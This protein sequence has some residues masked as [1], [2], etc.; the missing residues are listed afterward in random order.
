MSEPFLTERYLSIWEKLIL[1]HGCFFVVCLVGFFCCCCCFL[2][3]GGLLGWFFCGFG[4]VLSLFS[5]F[6]LLSICDYNIW[7]GNYSQ[8]F[9]YFLSFGHY[10]T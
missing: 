4:V 8:V 7:N 9:L 5:V 3:L 2:L 1:F 6:G 10:A